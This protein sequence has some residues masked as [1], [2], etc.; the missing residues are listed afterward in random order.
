MKG[1]FILDD[2]ISSNCVISDV[3]KELI[4][5]RFNETIKKR[6]LDSSS[7]IIILSKVYKDDLIKC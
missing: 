5:K 1:C 2:P 3:K 4:R 6:L 7:P